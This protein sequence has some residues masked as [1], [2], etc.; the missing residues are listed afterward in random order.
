MATTRR[1][2]A[3]GKTEA[4]EAT[5]H[6]TPKETDAAV[7]KTPTRKA[8]TEPVGNENTTPK[9]EFDKDAKAEVKAQSDEVSQVVVNPTEQE[10]APGTVNPVDPEFVEPLKGKSP[11]SNT[12]H[13]QK[14][15][16]QDLYDD[17]GRDDPLAVQTEDVTVTVADVRGR[18]VV[19]LWQVGMIGVEPIVLPGEKVD[20]LRRA[21]DE[22]DDL[23]EKRLAEERTKRRS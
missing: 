1:T 21:F 9:D 6:G 15:V 19:K 5:V 16:S 13:V 8:M 11:K 22:L 14:L 7:P 10:S 18:V 2:T 3:S 17:T 23:A 20:E 12:K 4:K